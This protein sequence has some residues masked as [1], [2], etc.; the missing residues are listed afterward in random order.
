MQQ[1]IANAKSESAKPNSG[2]TLTDTQIDAICADAAFNA[3]ELLYRMS[4]KQFAG[5]CGPVTA[6]PLARPVN[7][8]K[9]N[10]VYRNWGYGGYGSSNSMFLGAPPV[11]SQYGPGYAPEIECYDFP[12]REI[13]LVKIDG[14]VI[15]PDE[16]E[17]REF[18]R[19]IR[20]RPTAES[21]P[22]ERWGWPTSQIPDLPDTQQ[23][24]FSITYTYGAD[25]GIGGINAA[26]V[27]AQYL[28]LPQLGDPTRFP[29]RVSSFTRQGVSAQ[30]VSPIDMINK[31]MTGI[32]E[33]DLWLLAVNPTKARKQ[34]TVWSPDRAPNRRQANV[35]N[36]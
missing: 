20:I 9:R 30:V 26:I 6:R 14:V 36:S 16:Y 11:V 31:Q 27:L 24:T 4:G 33:V 13:L 15:P 34:A 17:L 19:L 22:T 25:P 10:L 18:K 12:I 2:F 7:S 8:D 28:A 5:E 3:T 32:P 29:S 1:A 23:G 21:V 35:T